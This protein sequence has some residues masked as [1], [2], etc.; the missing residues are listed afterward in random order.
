MDLSFTASWT[1]PW[2]DCMAHYLGQLRDRS[3]SLETG[4]IYHNLLSRFFAD[5][6]DPATVCRADVE[7]FLHQKVKIVFHHNEPISPATRNRWISTLRSFYTFASVYTPKGETKPLYE[8]ANPLQGM[9]R[10]KEP[11][12][13]TGVFH[14]AELRRFFA[15]MQEAI[16]KDPQDLIALRDFALFSLIFTSARR[17][18]EVCRLR[19]SDIEETV[20]VDEHGRQRRGWRYK[21]YGKG[22]QNQPDW[23]EYP[24]KAF[25]ALQRY[26]DALKASGDVRQPDSYVFC[27][28]GPRQGRGNS[29]KPIAGV[30]I[31]KRLKFWCKAAGLDPARFKVH[32]LRHSS[33]IERYKASHDVRAVQKALRHAHLGVTDRYLSG[34]LDDSA[35]PALSGLES[36]FGL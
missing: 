10:G 12:A 29:E 2:Q 17:R 24:P 31:W 21:F 13:P 23:A 1:Q 20:F 16:D 25:A 28:V 36:K 33:A 9:R 3:G 6:R 18:G 14:E 19:L 7:E 35:D 30:A 22:R 8:L 4:I 34:L 5:G 32:G 11:I 26:L 15:A 27:S